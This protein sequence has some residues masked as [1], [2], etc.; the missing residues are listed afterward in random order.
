M[1]EVSEAQVA[2]ISPISRFR[3]TSVGVVTPDPAVSVAM[4]DLFPDRAP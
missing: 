1:I 3:P 2:P 4:I